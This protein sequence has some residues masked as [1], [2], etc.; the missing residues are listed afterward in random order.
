M[1]IWA[2]VAAHVAA[3]CAAGS[4]GWLAPACHACLLTGCMQVTPA[5]AGGRRQLCL[6]ATCKQASL[7]PYLHVGR[8]ALQGGGQLLD[9]GLEVGGQL[10]PLRRAL[11][12]P[13]L[14]AEGA[15][16]H[17]CM[18]YLSANVSASSQVGDASSYIVAVIPGIACSTECHGT[19]SQGLLRRHRLCQQSPPRR[20]LTP[21]AA[22]RRHHASADPPAD[23]G[24]SSLGDGHIEI[25]LFDDISRISQGSHEF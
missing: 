23:A 19:C 25:H 3:G 11:D 10:V 20:L 22:H 18:Q 21:W 8:G 24:R 12:A 2:A 13:Q 14:L 6:P 9:G 4:Q 1:A 7:I 17:A 15:A 5:W 16:A